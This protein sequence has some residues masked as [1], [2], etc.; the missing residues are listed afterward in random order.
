MLLFIATCNIK[1]RSPSKSAWLFCILALFF[2]TKKKYFFILKISKTYNPFKDEKGPSD[3]E[4]IT[5]TACD[6]FITPGV[7]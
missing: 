5:V 4:S 3:Q 1:I 6:S 7:T 2:F